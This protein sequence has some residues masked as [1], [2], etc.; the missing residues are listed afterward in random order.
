MSYF[1]MLRGATGP[2]N[3]YPLKA[4]QIGLHISEFLLGC[5]LCI[6]GVPWLGYLNWRR[7]ALGFG[8]IFSGWALMIHGGLNFLYHDNIVPQTLTAIIS[9]ASYNLPSPSSKPC[10]CGSGRKRKHNG[11]SPM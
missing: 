2:L 10:P 1:V 11:L 8:T 4:A 9:I 6:L 7:T 5:W 3:C